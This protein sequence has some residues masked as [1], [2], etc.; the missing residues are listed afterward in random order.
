MRGSHSLGTRAF[1]IGG[2]ILFGVGLFFI[3]N[4]HI[5]FNRYF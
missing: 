2:L 3:S 4:R 5:L 1:V